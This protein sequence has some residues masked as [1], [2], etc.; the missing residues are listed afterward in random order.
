MR[1][2]LEWHGTSAARPHLGFDDVEADAR[3]R[4]GAFRI[5]PRG[6]GWRL[7]SFLH[8]PTSTKHK[9]WQ[10]DFDSLAE[11]QSYANMI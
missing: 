3:Q 4:P 7:Y 6:R 10:K 8:E 5:V 11:A 2:Y 9:L 1:E